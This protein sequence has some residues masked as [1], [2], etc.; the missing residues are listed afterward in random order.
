MRH[1]ILAASLA[2][3]LMPT[4]PAIGDPPAWAPAHGRRHHEMRNEWRRYDWNR[5]DPRYGGYYADRYYRDGRYYRPRPLTVH[6]RIYRGRDGRYYCRRDDGT[7]GLIIGAVAGGLLGNRIARGG[8]R[9]LGTLLGGGIGA[10]IGREI[11]R[12]DLVCR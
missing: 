5:P 6:D 10:I 11:D 3:L 2:A 4:A 12:G 8:S 7:T 1:Y 9:T